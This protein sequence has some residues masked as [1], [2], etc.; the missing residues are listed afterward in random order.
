MMRDST[1][2]DRIYRAILHEVQGDGRISNAALAD[3]VA[4]SESA[5]LR[6]LRRL[7]Q[8]GFI[9]GY[10]GLVDQSIAGFPDN[11]LQPSLC[12]VSNT[13]IWRPSNV[14]LGISPK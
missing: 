8:Q 5:C 3:R 7:E 2:M 13:V 14:R 6:R 12:T 9:G 11:V 1:N 4:L 10:V